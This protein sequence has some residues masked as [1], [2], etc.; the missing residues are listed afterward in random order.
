MEGI[1]S[2]LQV[3]KYIITRCNNNEKDITNLR[4]QK[5]L[6]YIQGY[7]Y[8]RF[9]IPA[10][11]EDFYNWQYGP[12]IQEVYFE[13]SNN[14]NS[15]I[16]EKDNDKCQIGNKE[17]RNLI[18]QVLDACL[19]KTT[20]QLV[21]MTHNEAPWKETEKNDKIQKISIEKFFEEN[22]PLNLV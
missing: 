8:K 13:Y 1:L 12:V 7:F 2:A 9:A 16:F 19:E 6:Y 22:N 11:G 18:N 10:F 4:L 3:A 15:P 17:Y 20:T 5:T 21:N 14:R